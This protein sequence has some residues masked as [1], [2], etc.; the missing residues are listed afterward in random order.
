VIEKNSLVTLGSH[1]RFGQWSTIVPQT[2]LLAGRAKARTY[3][4]TERRI[5][6]T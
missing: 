6:Q 1:V 3:R 2:F 5:A 4:H